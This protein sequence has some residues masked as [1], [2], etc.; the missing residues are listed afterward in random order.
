MC[1]ETAQP[2]RETGETA[3][4]SR[5]R[6]PP[7]HVTS[8]SGWNCL[9]QNFRPSTKGGDNAF[10]NSK[11]R[12]LQWSS[13]WLYSAL[14]HDPFLLLSAAAAP[15]HRSPRPRLRR[16]RRLP[17]PCSRLSAQRR[18]LPATMAVHSQIGCWPLCVS[19]DLERRPPR[20][21][22]SR[23]GFLSAGK[24]AGEPDGTDRK[25]GRWIS[26]T[27]LVVGWWR[28][29][30]LPSLPC[31]LPV[32]FLSFQCRARPRVFC[33]KILSFFQTDRQTD[34]GTSSPLLSDNQRC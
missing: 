12:R 6:R 20:G 9:S 2:Q 10:E 26:T 18:S 16:R 3:R 25:D 23:I 14:L 5:R 8:C 31:P 24:R 34:E 19:R 33:Y 13:I 7:T 15:L 29:A 32:C 30:V 17:G 28:R 4:G 1:G 27:L 22:K 21:P 11:S